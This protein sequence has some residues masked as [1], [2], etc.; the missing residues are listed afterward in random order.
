VTVT[1]LVY[2]PSDSGGGTDIHGDPLNAEGQVVRPESPADYLGTLNVVLS[3]MQSEPIEPR[4][5]GSGGGSVDRAEAADI[6]AN[7]GAPIDGGADGILLKHGDRV[8]IED[9]TDDGLYYQII[10]PRRF[11]TNNSLCPNW[12]HRLYWV[13]ALATDG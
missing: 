7:I 11:E 8:V 3:D 5:T 13:S 9:S 2:R 1:A 6:Q 10:G 12:G 4:L